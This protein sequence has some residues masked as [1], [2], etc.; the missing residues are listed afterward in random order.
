VDVALVAVGMR[1]AAGRAS[2]R[3]RRPALADPESG[4]VAA[5]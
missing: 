1:V 4:V 2:R 3:S 5:L